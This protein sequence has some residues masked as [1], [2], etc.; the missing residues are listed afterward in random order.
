MSER[1]PS[2]LGEGRS[3]ARER[4]RTHPYTVISTV[5]TVIGVVI[6]VLVWA[7]W[8]YTPHANGL[9][10]RPGPPPTPSS[11]STDLAPPSGAVEPGVSWTLLRV[12]SWRSFGVVQLAA[13][14]GGVMRVTFDR[15][16][17][18]GNKWA[19][20][21]A[22]VPASC[23]YDVTFQARV[24]K[25][26]GGGASGGYGVANGRLS[27]QSLPVGNAFQYDFGFRGYRALTYPGDWRQPY[28]YE[29]AVLDHQW[30]TI[31]VEFGRTDVAYVDGR[32]A[33]T[34]AATQAC[35]VPIL[36]VWSAIAEFRDVRIGST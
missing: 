32:K 14:S 21:I 2:P 25:Q 31:L 12:S 20:V 19:G 27:S 5:F 6:A 7:P 16:L 17:T 4:L 11:S 33:I 35:G 24:I 28:R 15:Q 36:R 29:P 34:E 8:R 18:A 10:E 13:V 26:V 23:H 1:L 9:S 30:H 22:T 3:A